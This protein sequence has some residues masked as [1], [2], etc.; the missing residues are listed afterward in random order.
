MKLELGKPAMRSVIAH[1]TVLN[2]VDTDVLREEARKNFLLSS[3]DRPSFMKINEAVSV[4]AENRLDALYTQLAEARAAYVKGPLNV[5]GN[6]Q[7]SLAAAS[8]PVIDKAALEYFLGLEN[9]RYNEAVSTIRRY[10]VSVLKSKKVLD[11][12]LAGEKSMTKTALVHLGLDEETSTLASMIANSFLEVNTAVDM[13]ALERGAEEAE[14]NVQPV[15]IQKGAVIVKQGQIVVE[16]HLEL[17]ESLGLMVGMEPFWARLSLAIAVAMVLVVHSAFMGWLE[18][19]GIRNI[20]KL[21]L[22]LILVSVSVFISWVSYRFFG[23]YGAIYVPIAFIAMTLTLMVD[24]KAGIATGLAVTIFN[25]FMFQGS[26]MSLVAPIAGIFMGIHTAKGRVDRF[27][28]VK[29]AVYIAGATLIAAASVAAFS[30]DKIDA[31]VLPAAIANG[32]ISAVLCLGTMPF[33]EAALGLSS[34]FRLIE[35]SNPGNELLRQLMMEAP[36]TYHHSIIVGNLAEAAASKIGADSLLVRAAALYHDCG[37]IRQPEF[38]VENQINK[39]NPHD[40][41][42]PE[43]SA[44]IIVGHVTYGIE[45]AKL[46]SLPAGIVDI[47]AQHHADSKVW[48]FYHKAMGK[49]GTMADESKY[50]YPGPKPQT[51]EA[52]L[53][54]LADICEAKARASK[55]SDPDEVRESIHSLLRERLYAGDLN[56]TPLTLKDLQLIEDSF[57]GTICGVKHERIAYPGQVPIFAKDSEADELDEPEKA[58]EEE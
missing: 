9:G 26:L 2:Q 35:V 52:A 51:A 42:P 48:Y 19:D 30:G 38:F 16:N 20:K 37:K 50:C 55:S 11:S 40:E 12:T 4:V 45:L 25:A 8:L 33:A 36:G 13:A 53:I 58:G 27:G 32:L 34:P 10:V 39:V 22:I 57:V 44:G 6:L 41:L 15:Y 56:E 18:T 54:M 47:I 49:Y 1:K 5:L 43:V 3:V 29:G 28:I 24:Q 21:V 23:R 7:K 14:D 17:T 46:H 31:G